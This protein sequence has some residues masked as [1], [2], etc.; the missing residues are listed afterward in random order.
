MLF[1]LLHLEKEEGPAR[2][3]SSVSMRSTKENLDLRIDTP[4]IPPSV[5]G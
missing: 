5:E 1:I 4:Q 2:G 3:F